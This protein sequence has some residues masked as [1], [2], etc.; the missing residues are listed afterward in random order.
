MNRREKITIH[1][2]FNIY[3]KFFDYIET[4]T[5]RL[6]RKRVSWKIKFLKA[7]DAFNEKLF[8][9]YNQTQSGLGYFYGQTTFLRPNHGDSTFKSKNWE[10]EKNDLP[11]ADV[12]W[13]A[14][15]KTFRNYQDFDTDRQVQNGKSKIYIAD[16]FNNVLD[17]DETVTDIE[18]D[19][20][21]WYKKNCKYCNNHYR[22][23]SEFNVFKT[24]FFHLKQKPI[25]EQWK[26]LELR[27]PVVARM[28]RDIFAVGK[29]SIVYER[30][31]S[32][33]RKH[34]GN[35]KQYA[36]STF[37]V[38]MMVSHVENQQNQFEWAGFDLKNDLNES[39]GSNQIKQADH[40]M[41]EHQMKE[42]RAENIY[43]H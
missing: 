26:S 21:Q 8:H 38:L 40:E 25:F 13:A 5:R 29:K 41:R 2:V 30:C 22:H 36:P 10:I 14:F 6:K 28:A 9:Y 34:Y 35:Q 17:N 37:R 3:N 33:A 27:C 15:E 32:I 16:T 4:E 43:L 19:Q 7:L 1:H 39:G 23:H 42:I 24:L 18:Q 12:Y 20:F 11:W 31:F